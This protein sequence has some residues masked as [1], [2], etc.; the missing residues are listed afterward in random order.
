MSLVLEHIDRTVS[1]EKHISDACLSLEQGSFNVLLGHTLSGK[2]TLMRLMAGLDAPDRGRV[3]FS[4]RDMTRV[5]VRKRNISMV[6]QQFINYPSLRV[7]DN[8]ASPLR[9]ARVSKAEIQRRVEEIAAMLRID[10]L[11]G[12]YPLELSGGQQQRTAMARALVKDADL[13][14]FDEPLVNLDYKLREELRLEMRKLFRTRNTV[15]VYA[16]TE[17]AEA[18]ALGDTT[19]L[20]HEGRILQTGPSDTV[21]HRPQTV[22]AAALFGEPPINLMEVVVRGSGLL[23]GSTVF[24][25]PRLLA[26]LDDGPYRL[27]MRP[28]HLSLTPLNDDDLEFCVEVGVAEISGSE[29]FL[30]VASNDLQLVLHLGGIHDFP[31]DS[32][33]R[34]YAPSN[35]LFVFDEPGEL[36]RAPSLAAQ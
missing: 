19:T 5:P 30:H 1:G 21:F 8:I 27:G 16:T 14:L 12:R 36:V 32:A 28:S 3:L 33:I 25:L 26:S 15:A 29:T 35:K 34:V 7:F 23:V 10:H 20:L 2:T 18:L 22:E 31:V 9:L 17:P 13:V 4:E 6:Y 24:P 11:L